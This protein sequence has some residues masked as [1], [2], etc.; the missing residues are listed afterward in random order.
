MAGSATRSTTSGILSATTQIQSTEGQLTGID[1]VPPA[2]GTVTLTIY[3][4]IGGTSAATAIASLQVNSLANSITTHYS[5]PRA[6]NKG[7]Y[8]VLTGTTSFIVLY[9][10]G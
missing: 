3:D 6:F 5:I 9:T 7:C 8:A 4:S 2:T 10:I 1:L